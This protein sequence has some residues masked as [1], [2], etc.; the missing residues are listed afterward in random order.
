MSV[1]ESFS[2]QGLRAEGM[3]RE[4]IRAA[5]GAGQLFHARRDVYLARPASDRLQQ[6]ARVGGRLDCV[7]LMRE[8]GVFVLAAERDL[9]VQVPKH[10][11][12][13]RSPRARSVPLNGRTHS[14]VVHWRDDPADPRALHTDPVHAVTQALACQRPRA[15]L[16][17]LDSALNVGFIGEAQLDAV[18]ARLPRRW[19]A[20]R[21]AVDGRAE[22]GSE[23]FA[24]LISRTFG[25]S[26]ELQVQVK[27]VGRVDILVDGWIIVECDSRAFHGG[28]ESQERD[29][30]RD[31]A[32]AAQGYTTLRPA[33]THLF[34]EPRLLRD[35][36]AG[37]LARGPVQHNA[38]NP[39]RIRPDSRA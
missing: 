24:R 25:V 4:S 26:V 2:Y 23:T 9:H 17:T 30:R 27:G 10:R 8:A 18:F 34:D 36:L 32:A 35:A 38:V 15:S 21:A 29:R 19:G 13:L 33:A 12:R 22:A 3:S 31:L 37:L 14:V 11:S 5:V 39:D 16:A 7:S 20:L 6:A 28:W 1:P